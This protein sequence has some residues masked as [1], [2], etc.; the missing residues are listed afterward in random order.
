MAKKVVEPYKA[1][2]DQQMRKFDDNSGTYVPMNVLRET[3]TETEGA[4]PTAGELWE[5]A[6]QRH[7]LANSASRQREMDYAQYDES[8]NVTPEM[9]YEQQR[10]GM[11]PQEVEFLSQASSQQNY[12]RR[13]ERIGEDRKLVQTLHA[14]GWAGT[15]MELLAGVA[16]PVAIPAILLTG[17]L[18][19]G[20]KLNTARA[21]G[22]S[23]LTGMGQNVALEYALMQ[24]DTQ[25]SMKDVAMAGAAGALLG[26]TLTLAGR[27][28]GRL[29]ENRLLSQANEV[30]AEHTAGV[31]AMMDGDTYTKV[32]AAL[33]TK[34]AD[35]VVRKRALTEKETM[36]TLK[37]E[38]GER[39]QAEGKA[40]I[41][42]AKEEFRAY[43]KERTAMI[44]KLRADKFLKPAAKGKQIKQIEDAITARK[45][46][47]DERLNTAQGAR[48][49][50]AMFD[51]L[52]NGKVPPS[53]MARYRELKGESGEFD[54]HVSEYLGQSL[55][56]REAPPEAI[57]AGEAPKVEGAGGADDAQSMGAMSVRRAYSDIATY[58]DLLTM[59]D[60]DEVFEAGRRAS[61]LGY[62][63][64]RVSKMTKAA[65]AFQSL[66]S[67]I[68]GAPDA[69]TRG[70]GIQ[71]FRNGT[72]TI[73]G[74]QS[75]EE[76]ADTLFHRSVPHYLEAEQA[77]E[78]YA[79]AQGQGLFGR[80]RGRLREEF[81]A[82]AV[83]MQARGEVTTTV[84]QPGDSPIMLAAKARARIYEMSLKNNKDYGVIGFDKINHD[85]RYHSV[86]FD[87]SKLLSAGGHADEVVNV[88]ARAYETGGI[89][90]TRENAVR[91][92]HMQIE[93][94]TAMKTNGR[95]V[96]QKALSQTEFKH[97]EKELEARGVD[98]TT[99]KELEQTLFSKEEKELM[100]PRAM[101]SLKPNLTAEGGGLRM[102]DL[103]D[104]SMER[105]MK[106]SSDSAGNAGL[107]SQGYRSRTQ[108]QRTMEDLRKAAINDLRKEAQSPNPKVKAAAEKQLAKMEASE[109]Q[110]LIDD[111]VALMFKEP[112]QSA[113]SDSLTDIGKMVRKATIMTRLRTTGLMTIPE[114]GSAMARNGAIN[115]LSKLPQSR[116]FNL[117]ARSVEQDK[118]MKEFGKTF[119]A[120]G[121]QEYL[122]GHK[123]Y[124]NSDFDDQARTKLGD[125]ANNL[126]GKGVHVAM[127]LNLF[128]SI[129]HGGE[130]MVA[131]G[132]VGNLQSAAKAGTVTPAIRR[133]LLQVGGMSEEGLEK[134]IAHLKSSPEDTFAAV[135]SL[136]S[137]TYNELSTAVRNTTAASF[138]RMSV[139]EQSPLMHKELGKFLTS[140]L[141]FSI[142]SYE[143]MLVRGVASERAMQAVAF[144]YQ[145]A[146]G[147]GAYMGYTYMMAN[148][149]PAAERKKY[150]DKQLSATGQVMGVMNRV[151]HLAGPTIP[152]QIAASMRLMPESI[153][154]SQNRAGIQGFGGV[155]AVGMVADWAKAAGA[156]RDLAVKKKYEMSPQEY[157]KHMRDIRR[158]IP[159]IDSPIYNF[160][161][162]AEY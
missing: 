63:T 83:L 17:G 60:V 47:L 76:L 118:F 33:A 13:L 5:A 141:Q 110:Q 68:D 56:K 88:I 143:K 125:I 99:I 85:N 81:D 84:P 75:A 124:N 67:T 147:Y 156:G 78:D 116:F 3:P 79:K 97:L 94:T 34:E 38:H 72:R 41:T 161:I 55:P 19:A 135:R 11:S 134:V 18:A 51:Q 15:G 62:N 157:E 27:G 10:Q 23:M 32:D 53:M 42:R 43:N 113:A 71:L 31:K 36:D 142:G 89:K 145:A 146:L 48:E 95:A 82:E 114:Y 103:I 160:T 120:T 69:G 46:A 102:V 159:F 151:G 39:V 149:K 87:Q 14:G 45:T 26:G 155:P 144:G 162:G 140:L 40:E 122:F 107:A 108:L 30:D 49:Q 129:Q 8:F 44:E 96:N 117:S 35:P 12:G 29:R 128:R 153:I 25:R 1:V 58:D 136:D 54:A 50:N 137:K 93:R 90:L 77:F 24:G 123:F 16:D 52:T 111:G 59:S 106:Y 100:S 86:I 101:F 6:K 57:P 4:T 119:S 98:S 73:E 115:I 132:I 150:L 131:R 28:L 22:M 64:P 127:T 126:L 21:V 152:L 2:P 121:H 105:V 130:E 74:H 133:S 158:V 91:L 104:T 138:L 65:G 154:S 66:S 80:N 92:A 70:L 20:T 37:R 9:L 61:Q 109:Y 139:G 112:L 7:W 148:T